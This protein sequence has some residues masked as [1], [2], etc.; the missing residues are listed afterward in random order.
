[1]KYIKKYIEGIEFTN[2]RLWKYMGNLIDTRNELD[3]HN[4]P[5]LQKSISKGDYIRVEH[6]VNN[7]NKSGNKIEMNLIDTY[8][9]IKEGNFHKNYKLFILPDE[10]FLLNSIGYERGYWYIDGFDGLQ[11][12]IEI[13]FK[14]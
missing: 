4:I 7:L 9:N 13:I 3:R 8:I 11:D 6:I 12:L 10:Y 5:H 14:K 2:G 1:M